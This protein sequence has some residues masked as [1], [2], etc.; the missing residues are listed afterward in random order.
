MLTEILRARHRSLSERIAAVDNFCSVIFGFAFLAAMMV[1]FSAVLLALATALALLISRAFFGGRNTGEMP[2][3]IALLFV[4]TIVALNRLDRRFGAR[5]AADG[6]RARALRAALGFFHR[7]S[8]QSLFGPIFNTLMSNVRRRFMLP[9][10]MGVVALS[11]AAVA[12]QRT[13]ARGGAGLSSYTYAAVA[14]R[15]ETV[16]FRSYGDQRAGEAV[17]S[18]VP[19]IQSD[20]IRDPYVRLF[21]P[22]LPDR[23]NPAL[24]RCP[25]A[26]PAPDR[27]PSAVS[28][29][30]AA[31]LRCLAALHAVQLDG[32]PLPDLDFRFYTDPAS[33]LLGILTYI[34]VAGLPRGRNVLSLE[35]SPPPS[36]S[37]RSGPATRTTIPFWI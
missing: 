3:L 8:G 37:A 16:D 4:F 7:I 11:V 25:G 26:A 12:F 9:M 31:T 22:Y 15:D 27:T 32:R 23:D 13:I 33:G 20:M 2:T 19:F 6:W 14:A 36:D 34:P 28:D 1:G 29:R 24:E 30:A 18:P 5:L 17:H 10:L 35:S 21:I